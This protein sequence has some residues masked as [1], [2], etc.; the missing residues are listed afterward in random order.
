[1]V[2]YSRPP[3]HALTL[4]LLRQ[5]ALQRVLHIRDPQQQRHVGQRQRHAR[6]SVGPRAAPLGGAAPPQARN[7]PPPR[8]HAS[9]T[10]GAGAAG[11]GGASAAAAAVAH[12]HRLQRRL[13]LHRPQSWWPGRVGRR[14]SDERARRTAGL[15]RALQAAWLL[16]V[17]IGN[18]HCAMMCSGPACT[19]LRR[20]PACR[21]AHPFPLSLIV[22]GHGASISGTASP[23]RG[24]PSGTQPAAADSMQC[25]SVRLGASLRPALAL[26]PRRTV[27]RVAKVQRGMTVR[28]MAAAGDDPYQ[29]RAQG[30]ASLPSC[31]RE[32]HVRCPDVRRPA[33]TAAAA[34][35][36]H[37][38]SPPQTLQVLGVPADADS[39]AIQRAYRKK[40]GEFKGKD[41]AKVQ[42]IEAAHSAIMMRQLTSRLSVRLLPAALLPPT[43][44]LHGML[45]PLQQH[46]SGAAL[47]HQRH[48]RSR[49][50]SAP[51]A[52]GRHAAHC[53][54]SLTT[55]CGP[56]SLTHTCSPVP[57]PAGRRVCGEGRAVRRPAALLPVAPQAVDGRHRHPAL[58]SHRAGPVPGVGA[59]HAAD[60]GHAAR[61]CL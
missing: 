45:M 1:M 23:L 28:P 34:A 55:A 51:A 13:H 41:E 60:R 25:H 20:L 61:H 4:L 47:Q 52:A 24:A 17:V 15:G 44:S 11:G 39:N 21:P 43:F 30:C 14:R 9:D 29:V 33:T 58:L 54:S 40:V 37:R 42:A 38:P 18:D 49:S 8:R 48:S 22:E 27:Q 7:A 32:T 35:A 36:A 3:R 53:R 31:S 2:P 19:H 59:A 57:R 6:P 5:R 46:R 12:Q 56:P 26:Q 10:V 16:P 50:S